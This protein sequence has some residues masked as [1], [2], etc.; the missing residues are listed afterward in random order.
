MKTI[1]NIY[2]RSLSFQVKSG[3]FERN[4]DSTNLFLVLKSKLCLNQVVLKIQKPPPE[5]LMLTVAET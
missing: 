3:I 4:G 2:S 5:N 1:A